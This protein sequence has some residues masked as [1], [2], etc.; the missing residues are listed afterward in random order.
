M[1]DI[2]LAL[3]DLDGLFEAHRALSDG[4]RSGAL[5]RDADRVKSLQRELA[6]AADA[7]AATLIASSRGLLDGA[8]IRKCRHTAQERMPSAWRR[9]KDLAAVVEQ[10]RWSGPGLRHDLQRLVTLSLRCRSAEAALAPIVD[11]RAAEALANK[12]LVELREITLT[13]LAH[14]RG[15][16]DGGTEAPRAAVRPQLE[17]AQGHIA[18]FAHLAPESQG[19]AGSLGA[20]MSTD[21]VELLHRTAVEWAPPA[22]IEAAVAA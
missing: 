22:P 14:A 10:R 8:R 2:D 3:D 5:L 13:Y 19:E 7:Y 16:G 1:D 9:R 15:A 11:R 20:A 21:V 18:K 6:D 12:V 17:K 4:A